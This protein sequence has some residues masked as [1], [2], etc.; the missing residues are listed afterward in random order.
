MV[1]RLFATVLQVAQARLRNIGRRAGER[2]AL[3]AGCGL[4]ALICLGFALGAATSALA[5]RVGTVNACAIMAVAALF[6]LLVLI[7]VLAW[8]DRQHRR[9]AERRA[10]L[11][12]QLYRA[13]ALS[14]VPNR[15]PSRPVL[16]LGLV[17]VGVLLVLMRPRARK[18]PD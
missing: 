14:L 9:F 13:A 4:A 5:E 11:D 10:S 2:A 18:D 12:R 16:G 1:A 6:I 8:E 17:A 7:G 3:Y 15:A